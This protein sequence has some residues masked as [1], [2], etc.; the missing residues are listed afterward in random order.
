MEE[1]VSLTVGLRCSEDGDGDGVGDDGDFSCVEWG[2]ICAGGAA[3][4]CGDN[5]P[6]TQN[7]NQEDR[8]GDSVGDACDS[9]PDDSSM[10]EFTI[11]HET[12]DFTGD[13]IFLFSAVLCELCA[14]AFKKS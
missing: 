6:G 13:C 1:G 14:S 9:C 4:N 7:P 8:D 12:I 11:H 5:C 2:A 10:T 3:S